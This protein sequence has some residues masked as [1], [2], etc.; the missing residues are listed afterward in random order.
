MPSLVQKFSSDMYNLRRAS[1]RCTALPP[2]EAVLPLVVRR[3]ETLARTIMQPSS[4]LNESQT[5]SDSDY[6]PN[7][8]SATQSER[9]SIAI[10][11]GLG[12]ESNSSGTATSKYMNLFGDLLTHVLAVALDI[13]DGQVSLFSCSV[14][15]DINDGHGA[16]PGHSLFS[17]SVTPDINNGSGGLLCFAD[18]EASTGAI[19]CPPQ[20]SDAFQGLLI[21]ASEM[22]FMYGSPH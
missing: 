22:G 11:E 13:T 14:T 6:E 5:G 15:P 16:L 2:D 8:A 18:E 21:V 17:R 7:A 10:T 20:T 1:E 3:G 9:G 4:P 19:V 12:M